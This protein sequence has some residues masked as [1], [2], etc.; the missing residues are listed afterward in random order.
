MSRSGGNLTWIPQPFVTVVR[1]K[2]VVVVVAGAV[3]TVTGGL[4][5]VTVVVFLGTIGCS[6]IVVGGGMVG[7]ITLT[8]V[9]VVLLVEVIVGDEVDKDRE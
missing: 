3:F 5:M 9:V 6:A 7:G 8:V 2:I 4:G 1:R